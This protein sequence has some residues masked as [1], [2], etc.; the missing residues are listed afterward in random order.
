MKVTVD[1]PMVEAVRKLLES[2]WREDDWFGC[3]SRVI[4][5]YAM[6]ADVSRR[7]R[8]RRVIE[9]GTRCGYSLLTFSAMNPGTR[10]LCIDGAMDADS[11]HCL[12]HCKTLIDRHGIDADLVVVDS[13]AIKSLPP[14]D[15]A[16]VDGDH[17]YAGALADLRLVAH[18]RAILADDCDNKEV[19]AAVEEFA[20]DQARTVEYFDDGLRVGAVLT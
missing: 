8:P 13:H 19:R 20:R 16:H 15:F 5:H 9:I 11:Y 18:C 4:F 7:F 12:A 17:S 14:A 3:D 6:K 2:N 1:V 10:F